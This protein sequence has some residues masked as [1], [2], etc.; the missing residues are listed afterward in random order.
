M[1][2]PASRTK[3]AAIWVMANACRRR[4]APPVM[5]TLP[6]ERLIPFDR[7]PDGRRGTNARSTAATNAS[8][9]PTHSM[10]ESTVRSSAR[11]EK[12][13][14]YRA[15][16]ATMGRALSTPSAAPA[17]QSRRHSAKRTRR[18][19][20]VLAPSAARIT[21]SPSRRIVRAKIRLATLEQAMMKTNPDAASST[22]STVLALDVIWSR[23]STASMRKSAP[24]AICFAQLVMIWLAHYRF[25]RRFGLEDPYTVF[26]NLL[27]LFLVLFYVY[28]LKFVFTLIFSQLT[29]SEIAHGLGDHEA[30]VL[31]RID[32]SGFAAVFSLFALMYSHAYKLRHE[33]ELN[34]V[35]VLITQSA[36]RENAIIDRKSVV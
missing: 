27:L 26:L 20:A 7:S 5:R 11:T 13:D 25:S 23:R 36:L 6:R 34:P 29:G 15:R 33:L 9:A 31:M 4:V 30:G 1:V 2:A 12:R 17:P 32:S 16:I 19:A 35:E 22:Q 24:F 10:L 18:S 8:P 3:E 28:P 14:A 21:S